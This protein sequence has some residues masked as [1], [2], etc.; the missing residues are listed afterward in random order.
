MTEANRTQRTKA[1]WHLWV[2]GIAGL[3]WSAMGAM[4]YLMT[5]TRNQAYMSKF[6]PEQLDFFYGIPAWA[7]A[8][9]AIAVWGGVLG[10][11]LL[12]FRTRHAVG[13]LLASLLGM[14]IT[15]IEN[16]VIRDGMEVI[17]DPFALAF[18]ALI[19]LIA[20]GLVVYARLMYQQR[21]IT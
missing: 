20:A 9:W 14:V 15:T 6:T 1:P 17:G 5:Q 10:C 19:F 3:L 4:D 8:T 21:V 11:L 2:V 7:V 18:T 12:L 13:V 16:Y